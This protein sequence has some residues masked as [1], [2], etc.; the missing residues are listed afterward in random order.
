MPDCSALSAELR[1]P[2]ADNV[3]LSV[4]CCA[5]RAAVCP[6]VFAFTSAVTSVDT[7]IEELPVEPLMID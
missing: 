1:A 2:Y 6:A 4:V 7:S 3:V 5:A